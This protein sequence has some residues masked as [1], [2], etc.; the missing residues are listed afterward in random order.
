MDTLA[1][2]PVAL[3][4]SV[5]DRLAASSASEV[6]SYNA[7]ISSVTSQAGD[8]NK[9]SIEEKLGNFY[10]TNDSPTPVSN[11]VAPLVA[12]GVIATVIVVSDK[13]SSD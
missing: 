7:A 1:A 4:H 5:P 10:G 9:P 12:A 3:R 11:W 13:S 8:K 2:A 6:G